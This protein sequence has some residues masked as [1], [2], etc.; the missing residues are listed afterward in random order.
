MSLDIKYTLV[1]MSSIIGSCFCLINRE[2]KFGKLDI[3]LFSE[4]ESSINDIVHARYIQH[5]FL[6][7][8][9]MIG[10]ITGGCYHTWV[11]KERKHSSPS[12]EIHHTNT[13]IHKYTTH[14]YEKER[15][16]SFLENISRGFL[17]ISPTKYK[18]HKYKKQNTKSK[19]KI[20]NT[21]FKYKI[22]NTTH[23]YA[24]KVTPPPLL[25]K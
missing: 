23:G 10:F 17:F 20:Q 8:R 2:N 4:E 9:D 5:H 7:N 11:C 6:G 25:G 12:L 19:Y 13:Q 1:V 15:K 16:H 21:K 24:K 3:L 14:K 18:I 22:Q